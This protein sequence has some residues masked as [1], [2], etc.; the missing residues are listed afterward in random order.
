KSSH[1]KVI[2]ESF[3]LHTPELSSWRSGGSREIFALIS[4]FIGDIY[5]TMRDHN[6]WVKR[7]SNHF[8][9]IISSGKLRSLTVTEMIGLFAHKKFEPYHDLASIPGSSSL[10]SLGLTI[11]ERV[12]LEPLILLTQQ[13]PNLLYL[14]IT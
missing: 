6:H 11:D 3:T 8:G 9:A 4:P 1:I 2:L 12:D 7:R 13:L 5:L 10:L 14:D